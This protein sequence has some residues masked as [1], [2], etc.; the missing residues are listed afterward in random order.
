MK[1]KNQ[2]T[3]LSLLILAVVGLSLILVKS[4]PKGKIL[5]FSIKPSPTPTVTPLPTPT[6]TPTP[7]PTPTPSPIPTPTNTPTPTPVP[8]PNYTSEQINQFIDQY[9]GQ[10]GVSPHVLRHI[11]LCESGFNPLAV[12]SIY[13]GLFQFGPVTWRNNRK[14]INEDPNPDLRFNAEQA[15]KTAAYVLSIGRGGIWPNCYPK[16]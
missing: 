1:R 5:S 7:T 10:Y 13:A 12:H 4:K 2:L 6:Q 8:Q 14:L 11:V 9:A 15:V 16:Q 3:I